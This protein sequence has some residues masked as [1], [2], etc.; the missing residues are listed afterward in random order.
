MT[1]SLFSI[2]SS[3]MAT[4]RWPYFSP[5]TSKP[6]A[7]IVNFFTIRGAELQPSFRRV[8]GKSLIFV[9]CTMF[10]CFFCAYS[11]FGRAQQLFPDWKNPPWA[12]FWLHA[13]QTLFLLRRP[14]VF[15]PVPDTAGH[16]PG[17]RRTQ[18]RRS[19]TSRPALQHHCAAW[20]SR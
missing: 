12:S 13:F 11:A 14:H 18:S 8:S 20:A 5:I 9:T 16:S 1:P 15:V 19:V 17:H 2:S 6:T 4:T 3:F 7:G 10:A